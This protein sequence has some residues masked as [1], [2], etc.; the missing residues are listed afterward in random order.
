MVFPLCARRRLLAWLVHG[1][2]FLAV[3]VSARAA[4]SIRVVPLSRAEAWHRA[5]FRI[6]NA[7][8]T[9]N[10]FDPDLV[11]I[12][13]VFTSPSGQVSRVPAFW[14]QE[15]TRSKT[16]LAEV[17]TPGTESWRIRFTPTETGD[18][19]LALLV[20]TG[21][22]THPVVDT[23]AVHGEGDSVT[24]IRFSVG[25]SAQPVVQ[26]WVENAPDARTFETAD[27]QSLPLIGENICWGGAQGSDDFD[28]WFRE[29]QK[30]GGNFARVWLCPW[31]LGLEHG[32][33]LLNH[34]GQ[35][36]AWQLDHVFNEAEHD[37]LYLML[38]LD[39]H[40]MFQVENTN[41]DSGNN[42]WKTNP[43]SQLQ[44]GPCVAP[45]DFFTNAQAQKIY[46]KRLRYLIGRYDYSPALLSWEFFNEIDNVYAPQQSL[47]AADVAAWHRMMGQ[48]LHAHDPYHHL[49]STS[50]TGGSDRPEIWS[51]PEMDFAM[52]H[53]YGDPDPAHLLAN[54]SQDF[55]QR[56]HKPV[57]IAEFGISAGSWDLPEDPHLRG[58]RQLLWGGALGGSVGTGMSWWWQSIHEE[59]VYPIFKALTDV[60]SHAGWKQGKWSP[61]AFADSDASRSRALGEALS[62]QPPFSATVALSSYRR[63]AISDEAVIANPLAAERAGEELSGFLLGT[64]DGPRHQPIKLTARFTALGKV[65]FVVNS[66]ASDVEMVVTV[67]GAEKMRTRIFDRDG[68]AAVNHEIDRPFAIDVPAGV[69]VIQILNTGSDWAMLENLKVDGVQP[70]TFSDGGSF[71]A[72]KIGIADTARQ[73]AA[74]YVY[75]PWIA[76][77]AGAYHYQPPLVESE[78][79]ALPNWPAGKSRVEFFDAETGALLAHEE[80]MSADGTL[81]IKLPAFREDLA[82][83]VSPKE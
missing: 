8:Q 5:E 40:G 25:A 15:F 63:I 19:T 58:F 42:Y 67:D 51:E 1:A 68:K 11:Q 22:A 2:C 72:E 3:I 7:P 17:Y 43:Y 75:S 33:G 41:W 57:M 52:Y 38:C 69:H 44:G 55:N 70:S 53:S 81:T 50:L 35:K 20:R 30:V 54:I 79:F 9:T 47:V 28:T 32:P 78:H 29:I 26:R 27:H 49:V 18:Y 60:M 59:H 80:A 45:N 74:V 6:E 66:V 73:R 12:D 62:G 82:V 71:R 48:W 34:Y 64:I 76:Y 83:I 46:R 24:Q 61:I 36:E 65:S 4:Q 77:P 16:G 14:F 13:A 23:D 10:N 31:S 21:D 39:H 37:G 56:Y